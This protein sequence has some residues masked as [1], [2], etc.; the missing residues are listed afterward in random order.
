MHRHT[1]GH[2]PAST[3]ATE[4]MLAVFDRQGQPLGLK[5]RSAVHRDGDWHMLAFVWAARRRDDGSAALLLQVRGRPTDR[6]RGHVDAP[7]GGHV[8]GAESHLEGAVREASEEMGLA[9]GP[10]ELTYLGRRQIESLPM[11]CKRTFQHHYLCRRPL[12]LEDVRVTEEVTGFVEV[13]LADFSALI[14]KKAEKA[15]ASMLT[16][17]GGGIRPGVVTAENL[18]LYS[19]EVRQ[20][21]RLVIRASLHVLETGGVDPGVF[22]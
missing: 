20:T 17:D 16:K 12:T 18:A 1:Q 14:D 13:D 8:P 5:P 9:L 4:E 21:F 15:R 10:E 7:A 6:F 19:A 2:D 11:D 22:G 3:M